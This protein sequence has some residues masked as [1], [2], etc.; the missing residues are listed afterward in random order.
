MEENILLLITLYPP[1]ISP[2]LCVTLAEGIKFLFI[3]FQN[4]HECH[5]KT[6]VKKEF[7]S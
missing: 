6:K 5:R 7:G 1:P 4:Q 2:L 3:F